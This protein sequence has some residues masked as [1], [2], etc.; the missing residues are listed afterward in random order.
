MRLVVLCGLPGAGK[1]TLARAIIAEAP[2]H[3]AVVHVE[4][5]AFLER[6]EWSPEAWQKSRAAA[7][8]AVRSA[9]RGSASIVVVDDN[10]YYASMRAELR[11]LAV[12]AG[13]DYVLVWLCARLD[14]ALA[15]NA[16]RLTGSLPAPVLAS[17]AARMDAPEDA[18]VR[19][20]ATET[21]GNA[22]RRVLVYEPARPLAGMSHGQAKTAQAPPESSEP[23]EAHATDLARRKAVRAMVAEAKQQGKSAEDIRALVRAEVAKRRPSSYSS[24]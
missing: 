7:L 1:S 15:R 23:S 5:D 16:Q 11:R 10:N 4:F 19:V 13:A 22:A 17:M 12:A 9:L 2:P 8:D 21:P 14:V 18:D 6:G 3:A 20:D 24:S